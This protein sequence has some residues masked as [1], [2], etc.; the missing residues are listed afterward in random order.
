MNG[1][2]ITM[3]IM[4]TLGLLISANRHGKKKTE[5]ENFMVT[6]ISMAVGQAIMYWGGFWS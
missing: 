3:A 6:V 4:V 1:A 5:T 2:Q